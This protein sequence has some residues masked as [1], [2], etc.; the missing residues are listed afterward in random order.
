MR[1]GW[2]SVSFF[3]FFL[4]DMI[5]RKSDVFLIA[6]DHIPRDSTLIITE[7]ESIPFSLYLA[8]SLLA[9]MGIAVAVIFCI[10]NISYRNHK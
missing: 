2:E 9:A 6:G 7:E 1:G 8:M 10:F 3:S 4:H 5:L